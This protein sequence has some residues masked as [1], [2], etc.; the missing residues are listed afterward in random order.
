MQLDALA[1]TKLSFTPSF[2]NT[3]VSLLDSILLLLLLP[4]LSSS[5]LLAPLPERGRSRDRNSN[6]E[7]GRSNAR[8][9]LTDEQR[10]APPRCKNNAGP[11]ENRGEKTMGAH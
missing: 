5:L 9:M 3:F 8:T 10:R 2:P 6:F 11:E 7:Q 4:L 1:T